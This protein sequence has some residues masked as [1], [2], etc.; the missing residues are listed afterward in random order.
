MRKCK[1]SL[2][3]LLLS[4]VFFF[5]AKKKKNNKSSNN[6][7]IVST[8]GLG[9]TLWA[10]PAIRKLK[11]KYPQ[12]K[13]SVLTHELGEQIFINNPYIE[14][15]YI[16][17]KPFLF[18]FF[19]LL[20]LRKKRFDKIFVFHASQRIVFL[21]VGLLDTK[22][23]IGSKGINKDLD[24]I[25]THLHEKTDAHEVERR[26]SL[27]DLE[28]KNIYLDFFLSKD[29]KNQGKQYLLS[30]GIDLSIPLIILHP[31]A[32][33]RYKCYPIDRF[34]KVANTLLKKQKVQFLLS[35]KEKDLLQT[36][37]QNIPNT[38]SLAKLSLR[39]YASVINFANLVITNDTGPMHLA[40]ALNTPIIA[41]FGPTSPKLCGPVAHKGHVLHQEKS[42]STCLKR[43]CLEPFCLL[44][45]STHAIVH[46]AVL[47]LEKETKCS[48]K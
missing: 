28:T 20:R 18:S 48:L 1:K 31:G 9:D 19:P 16:L 29:E 38:I 14:N 23:L 15:T 11:K 17:K 36:L 42:C 4:V 35:G 21:L 44:Q 39:E 47:I 33:D 10:T 27:D 12:K 2:K 41:L 43:K 25:F 22:M 30:Q 24:A 46:K 3:N 45:I 34:C 7:L 40:T 5:F 26:L 13:I 32:K 6:I 8:T 37:Q